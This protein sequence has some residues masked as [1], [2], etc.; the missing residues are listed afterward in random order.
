MSVGALG[1]SIAAPAADAARVAAIR[2]NLNVNDK[3]MIAGFGETARKALL[4]GGERLAAEVR[5]GEMKG[6]ADRLRAARE[7]IEKLDPSELEPRGGLDNIFNGRVA[8][9]HRFRRS[10]ENAAHALADVAADLEA[11]VKKLGVRGEALNGL[12]EGAR[13]L[14]LEIDAWLEAGRARL[15][16]TRAAGAAPVAAANPVAEEAA[17]TT[18]R[19]A[20]DLGPADRLAARLSDL[21]RA[22]SAALQQLPLVRVVQNADAFLADDLNRALAAMSEW[23]AAWGEL[24]GA[25]R[26]DRVRPHIPALAESKLAAVEALGRAIEGLNDGAQRRA[27]AEQRIEKAAK[28]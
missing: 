12:H 3:G 19:P 17:E 4:A 7:R 20:P 14:I 13:A 5:A 10:Y 1:R 23:R 6:A 27:E 16:E 9:L 11:R 2:N 26:G 18:P 21:D 8:R 22:R 15:A 25:G 24:L 28:G